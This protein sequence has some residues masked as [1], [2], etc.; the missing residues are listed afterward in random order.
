M[1]LR[2]DEAAAGRI[3]RTVDSD[4][5]GHFRCR[6]WVA[7]TIATSDGNLRSAVPVPNVAWPEAVTVLAF[8]SSSPQST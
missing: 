2:H 3:S 1:F 5:I 7:F 6:E 4:N 8:R